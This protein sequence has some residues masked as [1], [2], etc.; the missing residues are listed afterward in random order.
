MFYIL[1][2][3]CGCD[4]FG[5]GGGSSVLKVY[6]A[7]AI[8]TYNFDITQDEVNS[9]TE[10]KYFDPKNKSSKI[11]LPAGVQKI[12]YLSSRSV[13]FIAQKGYYFD[14]M[15]TPTPV[16][17]PENLWTKEMSSLGIW[18]VIQRYY[19]KTVYV[20]DYTVEIPAA[21]EGYKIAESDFKNY[22]YSKYNDPA[23]TIKEWR[24]F[25]NIGTALNPVIQFNYNR[26][27][28]AYEIEDGK[29]KSTLWG[30]I[31]KPSGYLTVK[32]VVIE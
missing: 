6:Y 4:L 14:S 11:W 18:K 2:G 22:D 30:T 24:D 15:N 31:Q 8:Y 5:D 28:S 23:G 26:C 13:Y 32:Y 3:F 7:R 27:S 1:T 21:K 17:M 9:L 12:E 20:T 19:T 29:V 16:A 25:R 10:G